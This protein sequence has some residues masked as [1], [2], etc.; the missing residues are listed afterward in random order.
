MVLPAVMTWDK[1][2]SVY[3]VWKSIAGTESHLSALK[4]LTNPSYYSA[5][6]ITFLVKL[7]KGNDAEPK[8]L[9]REA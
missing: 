8:G 1:Q 4:L 6:I 9:C 3:A 2:S 5:I 7:P